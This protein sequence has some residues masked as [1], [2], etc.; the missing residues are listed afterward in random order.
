[1]PHPYLKHVKPEVVTC[2]HRWSIGKSSRRFANG[3]EG[4]M[5]LGCWSERVAKRRRSN[6][7][8]GNFTVC[9]E[10]WGKARRRKMTIAAA[11]KGPP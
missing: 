11:R 6:S 3:K 7:P 5:G 2:N 9:I 4:I 8:Y 1:M 10:L